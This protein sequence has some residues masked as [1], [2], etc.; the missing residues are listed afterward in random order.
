[1]N[2]LEAVSIGRLDSTPGVDPAAADMVKAI[3]NSALGGE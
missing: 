3:W 1:M 2:T